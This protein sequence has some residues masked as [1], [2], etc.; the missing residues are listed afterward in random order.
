M[1]QQVKELRSI[2]FDVWD[3]LNFVF[4]LF[5]ITAFFLLIFQKDDFIYLY[6]VI[7]GLFV[8][9]NVIFKIKNRIR[10]N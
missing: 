3:N 8:F 7:M 5:I 6:F 10:K 2:E 1:K 9:V 4:S